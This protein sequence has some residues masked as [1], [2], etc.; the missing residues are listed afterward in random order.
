MRIVSIAPLANKEGL[1]RQVQQRK[2]VQHN[3]PHL[4]CPG[5]DFDLQRS[6]RH[7]GQSD[8]NPSKVRVKIEMK[9]NELERLEVPNVPHLVKNTER[10]VSFNNVQE[11][12][13]RDARN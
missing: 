4:R 9:T 11:S 13:K 6:D 12:S 10:D 2:V 5:L 3:L 7:T 1:A 8:H